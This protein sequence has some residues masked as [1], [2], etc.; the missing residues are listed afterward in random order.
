MVVTGMG[1][2]SKSIILLI[3]M[4]ASMGFVSFSHVQSETD[5]T[6]L[7]LIDDGFG[8]SYYINIA[9]LENYNFTVVTASDATNVL[10]CS[11]SNTTDAIADILVSDISDDDIN[12][13]DCV[14]VPSGAHWSNVSGILRVRQ[15]LQY[16][17]EN[18]ILVAG[19]CTGMIVLALADVVDGVDVA[20][21]DVGE[22]WLESAGANVT[23]ELVVSDQ[24]V[25]TGGFGGGLDSGPEGAPNEAFCAKIKEEIDLQ[26]AASFPT[27]VSFLAII[28][29]ASFL[30]LRKAKRRR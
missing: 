12:N 13:Y 27:L 11:N 26:N 10:G 17:R 15:I 7:C 1:F 2:R 24:G 19:I 16:A 20:T 22:P 18:G 6:I 21:N 14:M 29:S 8:D 25:I 28:T 23:D 30:L 4:I 5:V 3:L 9:F